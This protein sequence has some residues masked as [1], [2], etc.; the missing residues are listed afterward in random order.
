VT[1]GEIFSEDF[2]FPYKFPFHQRSYSCPPRL[3]S[4]GSSFM[5]RLHVPA[6][7]KT[8]FSHIGLIVSTA[9]MRP[10]C[11]SHTELSCVSA[12][13]RLRSSIPD[14]PVPMRTLHLVPVN[15]LGHGTNI[16]VWVSGRTGLP[17]RKGDLTEIEATTSHPTS[18]LF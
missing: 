14:N 11:T 1:L 5:V 2:S 17:S 8:M 12:V 16:F 9:C 13:N 3:I 18:K 6:S 15:H 4:T 7:M 10:K